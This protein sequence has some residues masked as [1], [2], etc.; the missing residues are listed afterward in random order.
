MD[1]L[2]SSPQNIALVSTII[3]ASAAILGQ[4]VAGCLSIAKDFFMENKK[5]ERIEKHAAIQSIIA[6]KGLVGKCYNLA[7]CDYLNIAPDD[8]L[9][10]HFD[11]G[12][13]DADQLDQSLFITI[14][15]QLAFEALTLILSLSHVNV[16]IGSLSLTPPKYDHAQV[17]RTFEYSKLGLKALLLIEK[18][19]K[20]Y[21]ILTEVTSKEQKLR[22]DF[23]TKID[24]S[25]VQ[26]LSL[27]EA[28]MEY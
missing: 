17:K 18:I 15:P 24:S 12:L 28:F 14:D 3:G 21:S 8:P 22:I 7:C 13:P 25:R 19:S 6:L 1:K 11:F 27:N 5:I 4:I 20:R 9:D 16:V 2:I 26:L 10:A 23:L